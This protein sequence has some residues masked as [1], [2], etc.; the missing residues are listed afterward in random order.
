M[1]SFGEV[2]ASFKKSESPENIYPLLNDAQLC[3]ALVAWKSVSVKFKPQEDCRVDSEQEMWSW[4]W[5]RIEFDM[6]KF[7][8]VAGCKTQEA[9]SLVH[10]LIGL[11]LIY[12]DAT[13]NNYA[14][15]YLGQKIIASISGKKKKKEEVQ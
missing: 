2:L 10:R 5:E 3:D 15:Q 6:T 9:G 7:G 4:L 8:V 11:R 1:A 14:K 12:P 13:I